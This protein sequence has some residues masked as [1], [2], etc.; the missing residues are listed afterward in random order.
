MVSFK[1]VNRFLY[2]KLTIPNFVF[3]AYLQNSLLLP[4]L[5]VIAISVDSLIPATFL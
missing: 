2:P 1:K 3:I 4:P 5:K